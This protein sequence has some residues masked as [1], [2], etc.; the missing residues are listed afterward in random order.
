MTTG[1]PRTYSTASVFMR[2]SNVIY[3]FMN[4]RPA[5]VHRVCHYAHGNEYGDEAGQTQPPVE[6]R[7]EH[8]GSYGDERGAGKV[9][10]LMGQK[11]VCNAGIVVYYLAY[12]AARVGVEESQRHGYHTPH[13]ALADIALDANAARCEHISAPKYS[14]TP[15]AAVPAAHQA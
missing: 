9:G 12:P 15:L 3:S 2:S 5:R 1:M 8:N 4:S 7:D 6:G 11:R 13:G 10:Q 14:A